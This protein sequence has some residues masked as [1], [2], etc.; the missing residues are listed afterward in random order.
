MFQTNPSKVVQNVIIELQYRAN[1][2]STKSSNVPDAQQSVFVGW[3]GMAS[4]RRAQ[5][6]TARA[7]TRNISSK[8]QDTEVVEVDATFGRMLGLAEGQKVS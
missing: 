6:S 2:S 7:Q 4:Q 5:H 1:V 3:T 8:V